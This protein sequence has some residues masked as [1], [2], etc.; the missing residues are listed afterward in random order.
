MKTSLSSFLLLALTMML[1]SCDVFDE[2]VVPSNKIT[3]RNETYTNFD[4]I[5]ASHAFE[6]YVQFS[7]TEE[8]IEIEANENLHQYIEVKM[9]NN[10][11]EIGM[12]NNIDIKGNAVLRAYIKTPMISKFAGSG[13]TRIVIEDL[14]T[15]P[16]AQVYLSGASTFLANME[17]GR[18]SAD[19]S[20]AS[21]MD[22]TG[23]AEDTD[24][25]ASGASLFQNFQ[26]QTNNLVAELSGASHMSITVMEEIDIEA[27]GASSLQYGGSGVVIRQDLS[28]SSSILQVN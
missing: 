26:F 14:I 17:T 24:V 22:I 4:M 21:N 23:A 2:D 12:E 1:F 25:E 19:I 9:D 7:D 18:L 16:T 10:T 3:T 6:V 11:L 15:L 8:S 27:S 28:G 20:G 13:A 5:D